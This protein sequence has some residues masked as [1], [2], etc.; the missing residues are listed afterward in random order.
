[1]QSLNWLNIINFLLNSL[2]HCRGWGLKLHFPDQLN[3]I[4]K[5][6]KDKNNQGSVY[7][8]FCVNFFLILTKLHLQ[9]FCRFNPQKEVAVCIYFNEQHISPLCFFYFK[10]TFGVFNWYSIKEYLYYFFKIWYLVFRGGEGGRKGK[11]R[12][13]VVASCMPP[14]RIGTWSST[15]ALCPRL[16]I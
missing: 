6:G 15:Q 16:G 14:T 3:V 12:Q 11:K 2:L 9:G 7:K 1:M 4:I 8:Y 10:I 13:C 5:L